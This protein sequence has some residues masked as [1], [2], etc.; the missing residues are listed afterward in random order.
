MKKLTEIL[1]HVEDANEVW[2]KLADESA[3]GGHMVATVDNLDR[4]NK[5]GSILEGL[6]RVSQ[7]KLFAGL[8]ETRQR[9]GT[10]SWCWSGP[11][12]ACT[13]PQVGSRVES[14]TNG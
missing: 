10:T 7:P 13:L 2:R 8:S 1:F 4:V 6:S 9:C 14:V 12:W 5:E 11:N 3:V